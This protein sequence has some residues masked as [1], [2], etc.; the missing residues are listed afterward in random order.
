MSARALAGGSA[1]GFAAGW[2]IADVGAVADELSVAY[3]VGLAVIGLFT[4]VLFLTHMLMQ[5]PSGRLSDRL[6]AAR[7]CAAG[8]VVLVVCNGVAAIAADP[9]LGLTARLAMGVGTAF[10]FIGGSD[11][12]RATGGSPFAQGLYGGLA[13]AGGGVALAVVP[14]VEPLGWRAPF[15]TAIAVSAAAGV[16]LAIA[17]A[18][19][20]R[21]QHGVLRVSL[22][23]IARDRGLLRLAVV[24]ASSFGISVVIGNW[25]V[26]LLEGDAG[27]SPQAAGA[28]GALTLVLGVVSRPFGGWV[29]HHAPGRARAA[30]VVAA[31]TGAAG[32]LALTSSAPALALAG[33]VLVGLAAGVPFATS[34]TGAAKLHP[35][36]PATA[37]GFVNATGALTVLVLTPLVGLGFAQGAE[38]AA[39]AVLATLWLAG[40][41]VLPAGARRESRAGPAPTTPAG[42]RGRRRRRG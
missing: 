36:A 23:T 31:V 37:V 41:L 26:T 13:T 16:L 4:T 22:S 28:I 6:G 15:L 11:Y 18:T 1:V 8:L 29:L 32:T 3:G 34:F 10:A 9:A 33:A 20:R 27:L 24:F 42:G 2:N 7:V 17:P 5:L 21:E 14:V 19:A 25:V 38:A 39:F 30:I 35:E 12:V 40:S